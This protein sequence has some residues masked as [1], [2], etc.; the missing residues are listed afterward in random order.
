MFEKLARLLTRRHAML[1]HWHAVWV[2]LKNKNEKLA[3]FW[4]VGTEAR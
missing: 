3:R 4:H 2:H 1:K